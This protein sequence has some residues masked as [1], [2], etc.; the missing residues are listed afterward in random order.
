MTATQTGKIHLFT[1]GHSENNASLPPFFHHLTSRQPASPAFKPARPK[2]QRHTP[3][4]QPK[5]VKHLSVLLQPAHCNRKNRQHQVPLKIAPFCPAGCTRFLFPVFS[6]L[7][8]A[9]RNLKRSGWSKKM[10][11]NHKSPLVQTGFNKPDCPLAYRENKNN[12]PGQ[13]PK[14]RPLPD[15]HKVTNGLFYHP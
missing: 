1:F 6:S 13:N 8:P 10:L 7:S 12:L 15:F 5:P 2:T 9:Q 4:C 14:D 3:G 11:G